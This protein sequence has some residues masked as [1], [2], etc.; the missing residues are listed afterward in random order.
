MDED[1][2]AVDGGVGPVIRSVLA[3]VPCVVSDTDWL[4]VDQR[5]RLTAVASVVTG[6][7]RVLAQDPGSVIGHGLL[8]RLCAV[9][10]HATRPDEP[11][12]T[13]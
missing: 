5:A 12:R 6:A 1:G 13:P 4:T 10:D 7:A 9:L 8:A 3:A 11:A 2:L